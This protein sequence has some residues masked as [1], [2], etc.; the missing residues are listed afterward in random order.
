P[1]AAPELEPE[2]TTG[3]ITVTVD[4]L[5]SSFNRDKAAANSKLLNKIL[6][7]TGMVDKIFVKDHLD[8]YYILL[9]SNAKQ[10]IW[11]VRC[12]FGREQIPQLTRLATGQTVTVQGKYDSY[13]RN[14][15][16]KECTL[17]R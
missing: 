5:S 12:T 15:I 16:L 2:P 10:E 7:V 13:E 8:I 6:N 17:V 11:N 4:E 3:I 9:T 1:K 14:I